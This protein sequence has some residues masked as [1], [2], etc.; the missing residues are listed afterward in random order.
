MDL[1]RLRHGEWIAGIA[2]TALL[3]ALF[4]DWYSADGGATANA[5]DSFSVTDVVLAIA[6]LMGI[7]LAASAATQR[8]PAVPQ[9]ISSLTAPIAL[10]AAI[11]VVV[12]ALSLPDGASGREFGLYLGVAGAFGVL[13]GVWR[14][15]GD[16]SFPSA[17]APQVEVTPL[18]A[19]KPR[20]EPSADE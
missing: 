1:R 12:H 2:G 19:P 11:L 6:A 13:I 10:V 8:S 5:W 16:Q 15:M 7:A 14:S 20:S 17:A 9:T 3:V 4:L 18:P